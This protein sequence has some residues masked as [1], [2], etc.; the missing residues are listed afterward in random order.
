MLINSKAI[1]VFLLWTTIAL[2]F[3]YFITTIYFQNCYPTSENELV[4]TKI[5]Q[6]SKLVVTNSKNDT[7]FSFNNSISILKNTSELSIDNPSFLDSIQQY[8]NNKYNLNIAI[9]GFNSTDEITTNTEQKLGILRAT[10]LKEILISKGIDTSSIVISGIEKEL[11]FTKENIYKNAFKLQFQPKSEIEIDRIENTIA[12]T[13]L[14]LDFNDDNNIGNEKPLQEFSP[15]LKYYLQKY[16]L[17]EII[18][19]GHTDNEGYYQNNLI[20]GL[21]QAKKVKLYLE[22]NG[23][24]NYKIT[25]KSKGEGQP[26][27]NKYTEEGKALNRRIEITLK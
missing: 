22:N 19:T 1:F 26:I 15:K 21:N 27:A 25:T 4:I 20:L 7:L 14:Y 5:I 23:F 9:T 3:H 8:L 10:V 11:N 17:T 24:A 2:T 6:P 16:P 18:I 12:Q 13:L